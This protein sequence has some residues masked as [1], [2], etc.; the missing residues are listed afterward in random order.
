MEI[1]TSWMLEGKEQEGLKIILRQLTRRIGE[2]A[3]ELQDQIRQLSL[4]QL[5]DLANALLDFEAQTDLVTWLQRSV[6]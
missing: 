1:V 4:I 3:A 2:I 5:E 6:C